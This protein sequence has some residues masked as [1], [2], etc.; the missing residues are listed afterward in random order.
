MGR[1]SSENQTKLRIGSKWGEWTVLKKSDKENY[2]TCQCSCGTVQ[3]VSWNALVC[4]KS[5]SCGCEGKGVYHTPK[6][7][8]KQ[9]DEW[10]KEIKLCDTAIELDL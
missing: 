9:E 1:K 5:I 8:K 7:I 10:K 6:E 2:Y 4:S 3:D